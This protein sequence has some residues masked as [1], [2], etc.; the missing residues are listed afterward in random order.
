MKRALLKLGLV[1]LITLLTGV[2]LVYALEGFGIK[3]IPDAP[4][5]GH[6]EA[7]IFYSVISAVEEGTLVINLEP[8]ES[9]SEGALWSADGGITW[10]ESGS[11]VILAVGEYTVVFTSFD[12]WDEPEDLTG[13]NVSP[14]VTTQLTVS[15]KPWYGDIDRSAA[16]D[17]D[18]VVLLLQH[19][20]NLTDITAD[21]GSGALLRSDVNGDGKVNVQ[22][23]ILILRYVVGLIQEFPVE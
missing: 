6:D 14:G 9:V 23:A 7:A 12:G 18:D 17:I 4:D 21:Y 5:L 3:M 15:Y 19:A 1:A 10:N 11:E 8:G 16:V 22:D 2:G 13:V 20:L